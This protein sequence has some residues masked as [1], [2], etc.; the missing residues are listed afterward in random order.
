M[1]P[2][3]HPCLSISYDP[4]ISTIINLEYSQ[5]WEYGVRVLGKTRG[6]SQS[7]SIPNH[8]QWQILSEKDKQRPS[9]QWHPTDT[10]SQLPAICKGCSSPGLYIW[11]IMPWIRVS[12]FWTQVNFW[13]P[14][15][16]Q[17][18]SPAFCHTH[19]G[20]PIFPKHIPHITDSHS[21]KKPWDTMPPRLM[22]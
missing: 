21:K 12:T 18:Q 6:L 2:R 9:A 11:S 19:L 20:A 15:G 1:A 7:V 10:L 14:Q 17:F 5:G 13:H 22:F 8:G 3:D 16:T 4:G